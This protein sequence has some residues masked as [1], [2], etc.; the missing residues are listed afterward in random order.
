M[1]DAPGSGLPIIGVVISVLE[2][3]FGSSVDTQGE[4]VGLQTAEQNIWANALNVAQWA[5]GTLQEIGSILKSIG[6]AIALALYHIFIDY[7]LPIIE[8]II[9]LI[10]KVHDLVKRV[11]A[12]IRKIIQ[13]V[14]DWY[15][16]HILPWLLLAINIISSVRLFLS[17][18]SLLDV[19]WAKKLDAD[20]AK[21]QGYITQAI[22]DV[23]TPLNQAL[24]ILGLAIDPGI[25]F[26]RDIMGRSL[27]NSMADIKRIDGFGSS[28]PLY[29][30]ESQQEQ[31][32][33]TAVYGG[34]ALSTSGP[35][36]TIVYDPALR[37]VDDSLTQQMQTQGITP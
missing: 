29:A 3:I 21:I 28:R 9:D 25:L 18:L 14:R 12:P 10:K 22:T 20:L 37:M 1:A 8:K 16:I 34:Q 33:H 11:L 35:D 32:T 17:L 2:S 13:R 19:K 4:I 24:S 26:R 23:L 36:G 6:L 15:V 31:Q 7:I 27:W 5:W 30:S